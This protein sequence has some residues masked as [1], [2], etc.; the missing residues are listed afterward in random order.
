M[1]TKET[2]IDRL[3]GWI[4][5]DSKRKIDRHE[6]RNNSDMLFLLYENNPSLY[7]IKLKHGRTTKMGKN[8]RK[9]EKI[10]RMG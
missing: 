5:S 3:S 10:Q 6:K 7:K 8:K 9:N 1:E 4:S 2:H